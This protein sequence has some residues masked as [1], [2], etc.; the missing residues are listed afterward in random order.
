MP[1]RTQ[2]R[3]GRF[4]G[5]TGTAPVCGGTCAGANF[6]PATA[7]TLAGELG[8]SSDGG[9]S[10]KRLIAIVAMVPSVAAAAIALDTTSNAKD[11]SIVPAGTLSWS[12]TV[13]GTNRLLVVALSTFASDTADAT[14]AG[15]SM[16]RVGGSGSA[17]S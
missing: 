4:V 10:M 17:D 7:R 9:A 16:T 5:G 12:H 8:E 1:H 14:Y 13:S 11:T 3:R 2:R 6:W 15:I